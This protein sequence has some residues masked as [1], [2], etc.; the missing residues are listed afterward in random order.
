MLSKLAMNKLTVE[1]IDRLDAFQ[2][3][4]GEWDELLA[5]CPQRTPFLT[6]DWMTIWWK[7]FG[8]GKELCTLVLREDGRAVAIAPLMK[9]WGRFY[10]R[11]VKL[12]AR[13][14][15]TM[16]NY[17]SNRV[18]L[19]YA[20]SHYEYLAK[21]WE[22]L[23]AQKGWDFLRL[24]PVPAESPTVAGLRRLVT[25][26][27][28]RATFLPDQ[29]SPY[30]TIQQEWD[31]YTR[32]LPY[33][34]KRKIRKGERLKSDADLKIEMFTHDVDVDTVMRQ[35]F[36]VADK[37][38]AG[39]ARTA[40]SSTEQLRGFYVDLARLANQQGWLFMGL[41]KAGEQPIAYEYN[42]RYE[43]TA[44]NLKLGFDPAFAHY[45]PGYILRYDLLAN[46]F[47]NGHRFSEFDFLGSAEL[48][49]LVWTQQTRPHVKIYLYHPRRAYGRLLHLV[50]SA[51][52]QPLQDRKRRGQQAISHQSSDRR[53][54]L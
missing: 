34:V 28:L 18:D 33:Q 19:I 23:L 51:I 44:Y 38:W 25:H 26:Q 37:G 50:Q 6:H 43:G 5:R 35:M 12:P 24:Y 3:L 30:L 49:K 54:E 2:A 32:Q 10:D 42:L 14:I 15:E 46:A 4:K 39:E 52:L 29:T 41:L 9:Y 17:H 40:I 47:Q 1:K 11:Y 48:Y 27:G 20:E 8:V 45:S 7:H 16:A 36:E 22:Y 53:S 13:V 21:L 31:E